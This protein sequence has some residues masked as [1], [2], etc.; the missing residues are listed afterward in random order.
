MGCIATA[1]AA[2]T[3]G[4]GACHVAT[5][6]TYSDGMRVGVVNKVSR[7]GFLLKTPE[8]QLAL[9][10]I[11]STGTSIGANVWDFSI[12]RKGRN[13]ETRDDLTALIERYATAGQKVQLHYREVIYAWPWQGDTDYLVDS[14][15]PAE[16]PVAP[17]R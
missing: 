7:K 6:Y 5:Q 1:V 14:V 16:S 11:A 10:G 13:G 17:Q 12:A 8:G 15:Q 3:L 9:E 4:L 2:L